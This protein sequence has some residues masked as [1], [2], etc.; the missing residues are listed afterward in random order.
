RSIEGKNFNDSEEYADRFDLP[1]HELRSIPKTPNNVPYFHADATPSSCFATFSTGGI[2][3]A[4]V[5][6]GAF[7][8]DMSLHLEQDATIRIAR[9]PLPE[10]TD[11]RAE[12]TRQH[13]PLTLP[14]DP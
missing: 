11:F 14:A 9:L 3:G 6:Q 2:H 12:D 7:D 1:A 4:E 10:A 13:N 5:D 8:A